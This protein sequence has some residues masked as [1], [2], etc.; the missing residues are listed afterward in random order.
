M[1]AISFATD[2]SFQEFNL[3]TV[4][5]PFTALIF[6]VSMFNAVVSRTITVKFPWKI[7]STESMFRERS[8]TPVSLLMTEVMLVTIAMSSRPMTR[9]VTIYPLSPLPL[10]LAW[11]M[12]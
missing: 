7:P 8:V 3:S 2:N 4:F 10:H 9:S 11:M 12:R 1:N 5:T 6:L